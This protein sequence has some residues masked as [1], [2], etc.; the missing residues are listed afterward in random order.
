MKFGKHVL[1]RHGYLA[2]N[3]SE[4]AED[5]NVMLRNDSVKAIM[6][7]RGG[8]GTNRIL[9]DYDS[10]SQN[11]KIIIGFS[12]VTSLLLAIYAKTGLITFYGPV[13][14]SKWDKFSTGWVRE[15]LFEG[16]SP[17][18]EIRY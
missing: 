5:I 14:T 6:A 1:S 2:G 3:D 8:W 18:L 4:R 17:T 12:D 15:I 10:V 7:M 13:A 11:R 9:D 16:N